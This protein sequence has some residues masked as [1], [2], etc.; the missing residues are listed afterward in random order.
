MPMNR[1]NCAGPRAAGSGL[2]AWLARL[3]AVAALWLGAVPLAQA[4]CTLNAGVVAQNIQLN[5]GRVLIQPSLAVG[6]RIALITYNINA[7]GRIADCTGG[8]QLLAR[9][10][11][12]MTP[13]SGFSNVFA[14]DV[15]GVG[16]RLYREAQDVSN[17]YPYTL[18]YS[19]T[20]FINLV[21]G[22]FQVEL[23]KTGP[24]TGS[25]P[26]AS[27]GLFTS[28]YADGNSPTQPLLTSTLSGNGITIVTS[29][30]E[31]QAGS[32]NIAVNFGSVS[33]TVFNGVGSKAVDRD[34]AIN[35]TCQGGNVAEAASRVGIE[36]VDLL[37]GSERAVTFGQGIELGRT[38]VNASSTLSLPLRA[39]Y[40]Q[41]LAGAVG[42]GSANGTATFTIEYR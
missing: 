3:G 31:V 25:G 26:I 21:G 12:P 28:Y 42:S 9:F 30:C 10:T 4:A 13:V 6:D 8:G 32:R 23:I 34:F 7:V 5:V 39:R 24:I 37:T 22:Y 11:R 20:T 29:T 14:T 15:L 18:N 41:T 2:R 33:K 36:L 40:V 17:F 1:C 27:N 38:A 35:L 19:G 16:I